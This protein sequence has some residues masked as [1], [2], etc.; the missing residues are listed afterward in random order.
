MQQRCIGYL[1]KTLIHYACTKNTALK[2]P[3]GFCFHIARFVEL[4]SIRHSKPYRKK[5]QANGDNL[6]M[7]E[8]Q[9]NLYTYKNTQ[10]I[11]PSHEYKNRD[12]NEV[13]RMENITNVMY[14]MFG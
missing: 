11:N 5:K 3:F 2:I 14:L 12:R 6:Q 13:K 1:Q 10:H 7:S 9:K 8:R 4:R